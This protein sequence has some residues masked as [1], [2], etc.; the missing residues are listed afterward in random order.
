MRGYCEDCG[1]NVLADPNADDWI[2]IHAALCVMTCFL[3]TPVLLA[4]ALCRKPRC[5]ECGGVLEPER[6]WSARG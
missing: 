4:V 3:W 2:G 5:K 6:K 1:R